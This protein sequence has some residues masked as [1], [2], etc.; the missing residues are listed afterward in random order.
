MRNTGNIKRALIVVDMSVEQVVSLPSRWRQSIVQSI[1]TLALTTV[2]SFD[3]KIDS[4]LWLH[5]PTESTLSWAYPEWGD[6]MGIPGSTGAALIPELKDG[7]HLQFVEK[8]HYSSFVDSNLLDVLRDAKITE[9]VIAGINTD[10]C[11]FNTAMDAFARG[12]FRTVVIEDAV[13]SISG[14]QGHKQGL[15]WIRAHLGPQSVQS[16]DHYLR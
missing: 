4:R 13:A 2:V 10:Y 5:S 15:Q 11:I 3:L 9:V 16:L 14:I 8:K 12:R 1:R 7:I 6:T